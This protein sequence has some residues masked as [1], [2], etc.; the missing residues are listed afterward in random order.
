MTESSASSNS[1]RQIRS[2]TKENKGSESD[3]STGLV[4]DDVS[5]ESVE[6]EEL[7]RF[8]PEP[9]DFFL[10]GLP[11]KP[12]ATGGSE[13]DECEMLVTRSERLKESE[14][15]SRV[16][17]QARSHPL[18]HHVGHTYVTEEPY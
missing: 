13:S 11:S 2:R 8:P 5:A 1:S 3:K 16:R 9:H 15:R 4:R 12:S 10:R 18:L 17:R 6:V 14:A 7:K